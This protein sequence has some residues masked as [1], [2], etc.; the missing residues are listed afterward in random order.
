MGQ[1]R[2]GQDG[3]GTEKERDR[4][5]AG[6]DGKGTGQG[7]N[8]TG[9]G[10]ERDRNGTGTGQERD[11]AGQEWNGKEEKKEGGKVNERIKTK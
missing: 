2:T 7:K 4:N 11:R 1:D 6:Q 10:Q 5:V 3:T 8:G 9:T